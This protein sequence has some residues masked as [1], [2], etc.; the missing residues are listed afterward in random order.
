M[1]TT[2]RTSISHQCFHGYRVVVIIMIAICCLAT[3]YEAVMIFLSSNHSSGAE[4]KDAN[5]ERT[6][7]LGTKSVR[8]APKQSP[9]EFE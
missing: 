1:M 5:R 7:L 2:E 8:T 6:P 4:V 9:G 3:A